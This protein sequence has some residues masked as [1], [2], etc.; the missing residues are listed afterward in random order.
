MALAVDATS[1]GQAS[2]TTLTYAHTCS[3]TNRLLLV[4][5]AT[6]SAAGSAFPYG[7]ITATYNGVSMTELSRQSNTG[8]S[9]QGSIGFYLIAPATGTNNVVITVGAPFNSPAISSVGVSY[10]GARQN[11]QPESYANLY[12]SSTSFTGSVTTVNTGV[13]TVLMG[14]TKGG[15]LTQGSGTTIEVSYTYATYTQTFIADSSGSVSPGSNS[16]TVTA[17]SGQNFGRIIS[18]QP[19]LAVT[20]PTVATALTLG[21]GSN[22]VRAGVRVFMSV[23]SI[24]LIGGIQIIKKI[25]YWGNESKNNSTWTNEDKH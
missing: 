3:G 7:G 5:V 22:L 12:S 21:V 4:E 17:S 10:T 16:L 14:T 1:T 13:W 8:D 15:G 25:T 23:G 19:T 18:I 6:I 2:A 24:L 11:S 9:R 20:V